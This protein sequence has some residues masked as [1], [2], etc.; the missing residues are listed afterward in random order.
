MRCKSCG[1]WNLSLVFFLHFWFVTGIFIFI[2]WFGNDERELR[3]FVSS[4]LFDIDVQDGVL[5]PCYQLPYSVVLGLWSQ[6]L[7][8]CLLEGVTF[9]VSGWGFI[10]FQ[11]HQAV[12]F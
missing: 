3:G 5:L 1:F 2:F 8:D 7:Q 11:L 10:C 9:R 12:G 6:S 4:G